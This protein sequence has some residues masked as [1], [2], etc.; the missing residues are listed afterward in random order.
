MKEEREYNKSKG[1]KGFKKRY[2][3]GYS[4]LYNAIK[5]FNKLILRESSY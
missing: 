1:V 5:I 2:F 4:V 3:N